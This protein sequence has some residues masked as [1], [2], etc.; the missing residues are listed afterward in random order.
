MLTKQQMSVARKVYGRCYCRRCA[1]KAAASRGRTPTI[2]RAQTPPRQGV[3]LVTAGKTA[4]ARVA[5]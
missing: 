5:Q 4:H 1:T 2:P 3:I